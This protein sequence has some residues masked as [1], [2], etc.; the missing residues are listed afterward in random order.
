MKI[1]LLK[2]LIESRHLKKK[3]LNETPLLFLTKPSKTKP[4]KIDY[5]Y[6]NS[7]LYQSK[8]HLL[9]TPDKPICREI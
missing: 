1:E 9:N 5:I 3:L 2:I 6:L 4:Q 7:T 8:R